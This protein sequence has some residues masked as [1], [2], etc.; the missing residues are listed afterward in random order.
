MLVVADAS[1]LV[2]ELLRER[3]RALL[4][5][6]NL[7]VVVAEEQ[8]DETLHELDRRIQLIVE[9]GRITESQAGR[10]LQAIE[11]L[12]AERVI[13]VV[14]RTMYQHMEDAARRRVPRDENDW[15]PVALAMALDTG[16]VTNDKDF[17][18]CGC[19]TWTIETLRA[20][21]ELP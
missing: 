3:G 20:E 10:I 9:Q 6:P 15:P 21:L 5:T 19:P 7:R 18:G 4:T 16:I 11:N 17:L 14:P 8:W 13:E 12:I 2:A 1:V